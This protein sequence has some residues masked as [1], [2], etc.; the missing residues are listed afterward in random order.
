MPSTSKWLRRSSGGWSRERPPVPA[1]GVA[2]VRPARLT[3]NVRAAHDPKPDLTS[4][5]YGYGFQLD[6]QRSIAG[7]GGGFPGISSNLD[8]FKGTGYV[9]VVMSNYG[10]TGQP[11]VDRI[12]ALVRA[13]T[14]PLSR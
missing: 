1:P 6:T 8:I 2:Q 3:Y 4:L 11:V 12:R 13:R 7:H 10:D 14:T 9:A 5:Q